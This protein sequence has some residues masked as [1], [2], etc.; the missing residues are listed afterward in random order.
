MLGRLFGRDRASEGMAT[1]LYGAVVAQ[2][3]SPALY[4]VLGVPDTVGGRFEMVVLHAV[5]MIERLKAENT[6]DADATGQHVF[7]LFC[8]DM[9]RS[10]R[11]LGVGDMAVP[12][13]M[14][15]MGSGFYG[16]A[17]AY[18][19]ALAARDA[20]ALAAAIARNTQRDDGAGTNA[21]ALAAYALAAAERLADRVPQRAG[22]RLRGFSRSG[23]VCVRW[24]CRVTI[25][26]LS[27]PV[28]V[29]EVRR[30]GSVAVDVA[31]NEADRAALAEAYD[32][33]VTAMAATAT[34]TAH[35]D[36]GILVEGRVI[37]DIVQTCVVSL[38][39]VDQH[40][41][42]PFEARFAPPGSREHQP[43]KPHAEVVVDPNA[44]DPPE[45]LT[46]PTID[47]GAVVGGG[48]RAR[49]RSV[50]ARAGC[51]AAG[52]RGPRRGRRFALRGARRSHQAG[53]IAVAARFGKRRGAFV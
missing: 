21:A 8:L 52:G 22:R 42:E 5:L 27:C 26:V 19:A 4:S 31:T 38:V 39:P 35:A 13:R 7:D 45:P 15:Q 43:P 3:R 33:K 36:G 25:P 10:L 16:R 47:V 44:P 12:K 48:V 50:S 14:K 51:D 20:D 46:G 6:T 11:E 2:A 1:G 29:A 49:H 32:V 41:D 37:A 17:D 18:R 9:D 34:L 30:S 53:K 40:I 28:D 23:R 24:C